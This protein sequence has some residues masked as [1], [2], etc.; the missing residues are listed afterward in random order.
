MRSA[1]GEGTVVTVTKLPV[2]FLPMVFSKDSKKL[3]DEFL[4]HIVSN[5]VIAAWA[6]LDVVKV[7]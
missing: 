7:L 6:A 5:L 3:F 4:A 2:I 1:G